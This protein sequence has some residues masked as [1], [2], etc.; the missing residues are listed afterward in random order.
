VDCLGGLLIGAV[1]LRGAGEK[2]D[3]AKVGTAEVGTGKS[4]SVKVGTG[5]VGTGQ[6]G[7]AEVD[8]GQ[9]GAPEIGPVAVTCVRSEYDRWASLRLAWLKS[10]P[11]KMELPSQAPSRLVYNK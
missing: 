10:A 2:E 4:G 11:R 7:V 6:L 3:T 1:I 5:K 9:V 8:L